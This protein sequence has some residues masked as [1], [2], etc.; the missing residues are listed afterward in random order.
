MSNFF[1]LCGFSFA[2]LVGVCLYCIW[3]EIKH[4]DDF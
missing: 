4:H 1:T 3:R 2:F